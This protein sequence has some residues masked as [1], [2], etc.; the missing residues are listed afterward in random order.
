MTSY[1]WDPTA[2]NN[3]KSETLMLCY[4]RGIFQI[5]TSQAPGMKCQVILKGGSLITNQ[6]LKI[7]GSWEC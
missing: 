6:E 3:S 5:T 2:R 7:M 4:Q 1:D